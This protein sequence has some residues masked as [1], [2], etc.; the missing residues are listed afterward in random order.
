[1]MIGG[2]DDFGVFWQDESS[3]LVRQADIVKM[4]FESVDE[5]SLIDKYT[6]RYITF[7]NLKAKYR[8]FLDNLS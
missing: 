1:M 4:R 3:R 8:Q 5:L 2:V 7:Q 6:L